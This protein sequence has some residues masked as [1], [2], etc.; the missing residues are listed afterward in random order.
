MYYLES[1][2][3][4]PVFNLALE[5]HLFD[6]LGRREDLFMLW[7]NDNTIVVGR[8]QDTSSEVNG[9]FVRAHDVRVVR[10]LSG[11]GAVY[12]D[13]GNL[14]FTFIAGAGEGMALDLRLFCVPVACALSEFGIKAEISGRNDITVDGMKCSGNAQYKKNGRVMHHGTILFDSD[15]SIVAQALTP[16]AEKLASKGVKSVRSRVTNVKPY[17]P[18][19]TTLEDFKTALV[20]AVFETEGPAEYALSP[21]DLQSVEALR[22]RRYATHTWNYGESPR[23]NLRRSGRVDGVGRLDVYLSVA[24]GLIQNLTVFGDFFGEGENGSLSAALRG[25]PLQRDALLAE[26]RGLD[27]DRAF[28]N[29]EAEDFCNI[30]LGEE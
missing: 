4:D 21:T 14:N 1:P 23:Y 12:H 8:H 7:Q 10:R 9:E 22:V 28:H 16:P 3:T 18:A 20:H 27:L 19:G 17:L 15:L 25:C 5:Q 29:L 13:L 24:A 2:S 26:L 11:G 6:T 30:L